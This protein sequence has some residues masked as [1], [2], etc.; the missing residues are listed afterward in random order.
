MSMEVLKIMA[1]NRTLVGPRW[2]SVE[3]LIANHSSLGISA[4]MLNIRCNQYFNLLHTTSCRYLKIGF[5]HEP[6]AGYLLN[7]IILS[8]LCR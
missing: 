2:R 6:L 1:R 8:W 7:R 3:I 4:H 5:T